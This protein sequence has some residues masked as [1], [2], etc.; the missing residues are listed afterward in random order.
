MTT[1]KSDLEAKIDALSTSLAEVKLMLE[2]KFAS[3]ESAQTQASQQLGSLAVEMKAHDA[4]LGVLESAR[5]R[6]EGAAAGAKY[7]GHL[8]WVALLAASHAVSWF[9]RGGSK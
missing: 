9:L 2:R 7:L 6:A 1:R 4:R 3:L 5:A 8:V